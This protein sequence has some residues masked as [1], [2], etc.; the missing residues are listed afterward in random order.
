MNNSLFDNI[1]RIIQD[2]KMNEQTEVT[3]KYSSTQ[4]DAPV[5]VAEKILAFS[6]AIPEEKIYRDPEDPSLGRELNSHVTIKYGLETTN[7]EDVEKLVKES[8]IKEISIVLKEIS[9]FE[10]DTPY[11]VLK[12]DVDSEELHELHR[13]FSTLP[14]SD[15]HT[16]YIPHL[17]I[18]YVKKGASAEYVGAKDFNGIS[19]RTDYF[20]FKGSDGRSKLIRLVPEI[21][22]V[23]SDQFLDTKTSKTDDTEELIKGMNPIAQFVPWQ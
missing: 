1:N 16:N 19:F 22:E 13:I 9:L 20:Y 8:G 2:T 7:A 3:Y 12:I 5:E 11:D 6:L 4:V 14:N 23:R 10:C 18:A 21:E 15:T 17:T